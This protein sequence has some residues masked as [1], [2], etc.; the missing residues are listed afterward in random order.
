M[1]DLG[2]K[3]IKSSD[4]KKGFK[5]SIGTFLVSALPKI[6]EACIGHPGR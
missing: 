3:M 5:Y 1:D 4:E 2:F 6:V